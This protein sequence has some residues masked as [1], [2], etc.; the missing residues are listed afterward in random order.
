[1]MDIRVRFLQ[2]GISMSN[3]CLV[4]LVGSTTNREKPLTLW[5][6]ELW[7]AGLQLATLFLGFRQLERNLTH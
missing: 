4:V 6:E 2:F 5:P 3:L 1:M 7:V